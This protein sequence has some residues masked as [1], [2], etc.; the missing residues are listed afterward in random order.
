MKCPMCGLP[1]EW[2]DDGECPNY[3]Q[4]ANA[5]FMPEPAD[6][7]ENTDGKKTHYGI[8]QIGTNWAIIQ[9]YVNDYGRRVNE[10]CEVREER[11]DLVALLA[12]YQLVGTVLWG[13]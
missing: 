11:D 4:A 6:L 10:L 7:R 2:H 8:R 3:E 1:E 5:L 9:S 13:G 12:E